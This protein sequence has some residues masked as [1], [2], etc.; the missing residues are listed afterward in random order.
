[1]F[2]LSVQV[3][4]NHFFQEQEHVKGDGGMEDGGML[5]VMS[6][7]NLKH[8]QLRT[9]KLHSKHSSGEA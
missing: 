7:A 3:F 9:I 8:R 5:S 1:M 4:S 2:Q 6:E